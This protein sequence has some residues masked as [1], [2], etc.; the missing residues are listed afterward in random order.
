M[1]RARPYVTRDHV[2]RLIAQ[3]F[4]VAAHSIDHPRFSSISLAEQHRQ[5]DE[6]VTNVERWFHPPRRAFAFPFSADGVQLDF[7]ERLKREGAV[8]IFFGTGWNFPGQSQPI[9]ER[10]S[11]DSCEKSAKAILKDAYSRNVVSRLRELTCRQCARRY[12]GTEN[13]REIQAIHDEQEAEIL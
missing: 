12:D 13:R 8:E 11:M 5:I 1:Q 9:I 10:I 4:S 7:F 6:S 2:D 3:G